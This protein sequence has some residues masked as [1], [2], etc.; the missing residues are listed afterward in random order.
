M[1]DYI[2]LD[3]LGQ[4]IIVRT[5]T[6]DDD[7]AA[8]KR[9]DGG[10]DL[11]QFIRDNDDAEIRLD[12]KGTHE[13]YT[14]HPCGKL[15]ARSVE[16]FRIDRFIRQNRRPVVADY[17]CCVETLQEAAL[18]FESGN[19]EAGTDALMVARDCLLDGTEEYDRAQ[20]L[21]GAAMFLIRDEHKMLAQLAQNLS[22]LVE[23]DQNGE[24]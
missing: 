15:E 17:G 1:T 11:T 24:I 10:G 18:A 23:R 4:K 21:V 19:V 2:F 5:P 7:H 16:E 6:I 22:E 20:T 12:M 13:K 3:A 8:A 14:I 9:L